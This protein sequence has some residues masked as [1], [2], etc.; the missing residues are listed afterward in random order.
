MNIDPVISLEG[1]SISPVLQKVALRYYIYM[2][3]KR[4]DY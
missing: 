4:Q 1:E 2:E 3:Q